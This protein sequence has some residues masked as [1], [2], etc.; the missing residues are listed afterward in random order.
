MTKQSTLN[1]ITNAGRNLGLHYIHAAHKAAKLLG[2]GYVP[3]EDAP[4]NMDK[5][6]VAFVNAKRTG[7]FPV[8]EGGSAKTVYGSKEANWAFRYL[9]DI[10]HIQSGLG[11]TTL[12]E[13]ELAVQESAKIAKAM[14]EGSAEQTVFLIDTACQS[15]YEQ[16][17]GEFPDNQ[18]A[19]AVLVWEELES[20]GKLESPA[21]VDL[22]KAV[23]R[24]IAKQ[25]AL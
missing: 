5:L 12:E 9:H 23:S 19:F 2:F 1:I 11:M 22:V 17:Q 15:I 14:G 10:A 18:L 13:V 7:V 4:D 8:W 20:L 6:A 16:Q 24:V 3:V 25:G 21:V